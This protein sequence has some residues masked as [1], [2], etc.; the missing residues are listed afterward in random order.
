VWL[1]FRDRT[2]GEIDLGPELQGSV[3]A[4]SRDAATFTAPRI[5]PE[6]HTVVWPN[7]ADVAGG[8]P[9]RRHQGHGLTHAAA[10]DERRGTFRPGR[11]RGKR[12]SQL[13][14]RSLAVEQEHP[15]VSGRSWG[16]A[17]AG[18]LRTG[19]MSPERVS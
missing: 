10:A 5:D 16:A 13:N 8:G 6:F 19:L 14:G 18:G 3:F 11:G 1:R 9:S 2:C 7:G 4:P 12:R 17:A 15:A